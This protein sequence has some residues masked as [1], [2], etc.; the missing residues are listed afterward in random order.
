MSRL[1]FVEEYGNSVSHKRIDIMLDYFQEFPTIIEGQRRIL[2]FQIKDELNFLRQ[3]HHV[4]CGTV[5]LS[6]ELSDPTA[7][8][9]IENVMIEDAL[10]NETDISGLLCGMQFEEKKFFRRQFYILK[11]MQEEYLILQTQMLLLS[12]CE[13]KL[14]ELYME[15]GHDYRKIANQ[16]G[17]QMDS[18][19]RRIWEIRKKIRVKT[20]DHMLEKI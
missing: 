1:G 8:E 16:Q 17:I 13:K 10:L 14:F 7:K 9:A 3:P 11:K 5:R 6:Q 15:S 20:A 18:A 4:D 19:R 12:N 2:I